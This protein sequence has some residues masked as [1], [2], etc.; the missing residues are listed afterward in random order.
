[1]AKNIPTTDTQPESKANYCAFPKMGRPLSKPVLKTC[2]D[3]ATEG[4]KIYRCFKQGALRESDFRALFFSLKILRDLIRD[5]E[6]TELSE[7]V[8]LLKLTMQKSSELNI[9]DGQEKV[10]DDDND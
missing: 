6:L 9:N 2:A 3:L 1:M 5:H 8:E 7:T 10:K 4:A